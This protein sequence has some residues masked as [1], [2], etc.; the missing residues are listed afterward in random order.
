MDNQ[1]NS[2]AP[3]PEK[4]LN[5]TVIVVII[6]VVVLGALA[7]LYFFTDVFDGILNNEASNEN[8][9]SVDTN[10]GSEAPLTNTT[11]QNNN[12][13]SSGGTVDIQNVNMPSMNN[14][15]TYESNAGFSFQ[16][17]ATY[18]E[19]DADQ[20]IGLYSPDD[21]TDSALFA[22]PQ[23]CHD[24]LT[25][26]FN[27]DTFMDIE[28]T[29]SAIEYFG[30]QCIV[31]EVSKE[32]TAFIERMNS[33]LDS[34]TNT[35]DAK[36]TSYTFAGM[37]G[38]IISSLSDLDGIDNYSVVLSGTAGDYEFV[39]DLSGH[40]MSE[41]DMVATV[42]GIAQSMDVDESALTE[43]DPVADQDDDN[44]T[45]EEEALHGTN[46]NL[47]DT[48]G[49]GFNDGDEVNNCFN[50][51]GEGKMTGEYFKDHC[52]ANIASSEFSSLAM[53]E[54][55]EALCTAW[56]PIAEDYINGTITKNLLATDWY[57]IYPVICETTDTLMEVQACSLVSSYLVS[58]CP[59]QG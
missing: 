57:D 46:V 13:S 59:E 36:G 39:I 45:D 23:Y 50:P 12:A 42:L 58:L 35:S 11:E 14:W 29:A 43:V 30:D 9:N 3:I 31:L 18:N 26:L 20:L 54:N 38:T 41:D 37:Q 44:L 1:D 5:K 22:S 34:D 6:V 56:M 28:I 25:A 49:D 52:V 53:Y 47:A 48:D 8:T 24:Q 2:Q 15:K 19:Y 17:P 55:R 10:A 16:Y 51:I 21:V 40:G 33:L 4:Q 27:E 7:E 32:S